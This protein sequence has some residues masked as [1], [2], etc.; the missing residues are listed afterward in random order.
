MYGYIEKEGLEY[1]IVCDQLDIIEELEERASHLYDTVEQDE[2]IDLEIADMLLDIIDN[3]T[4]NP[5]NW[6]ADSTQRE[7]E[8]DQYREDIEEIE[9]LYKSYL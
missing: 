3:L 7:T 5:V 9:A 1:F 6:D 2:R 8:I 4:C